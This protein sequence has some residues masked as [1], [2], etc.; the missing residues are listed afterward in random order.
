MARELERH[1]VLVAYMAVL[2]VLGI[3]PPSASGVLMVYSSALGLSE[4]VY[5]LLL[6]LHDL[7]FYL[8]LLFIFAHLFAGSSA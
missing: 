8:T 7:G 4:D 3:L 1:S 6:L 2:P 5:R